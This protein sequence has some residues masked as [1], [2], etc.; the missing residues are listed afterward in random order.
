VSNSNSNKAES[1][2]L[3]IIREVIT[4]RPLYYIGVLS[5]TTLGQEPGQL[6][7]LEYFG[8][9]ENCMRNNN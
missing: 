1:I 6:M 8:W 9:F 5:L 7:N 4:S 3:E 2:L